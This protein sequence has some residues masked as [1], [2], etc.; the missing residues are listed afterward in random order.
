MF[1]WVLNYVYQN[2]RTEISIESSAILTILFR[3]SFYLS[4]QK[5]DRPPLNTNEAKFLNKFYKDGTYVFEEPLKH[6]LG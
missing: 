1:G 3:Y 5:V 2:G 4:I 6:V